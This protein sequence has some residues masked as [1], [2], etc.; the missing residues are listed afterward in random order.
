MENLIFTA[1]AGPSE[2]ASAI[3]CSSCKSS[4]CSRLSVR[5]LPRAAI[6]SDNFF[7]TAVILI[8][9]SLAN[10]F[11][12]S[13]GIATPPLTVSHSPSPSS[14]SRF[15]FRSF[16]LRSFRCS[17]LFALSSSS[18]LSVALYKIMSYNIYY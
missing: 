3:D 11:G 4:I 10:I 12:F 7:S 14:S 8:S 17:F 18:S 5:F 15:F 13:D 16:S 2:C 1:T 9:A 6:I